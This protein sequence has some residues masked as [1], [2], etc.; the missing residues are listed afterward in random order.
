MKAESPVR[1]SPLDML[2]F[3]QCT[4][5]FAEDPERVAEHVQDCRWCAEY[6]RQ[7]AAILK[8]SVSTEGWWNGRSSM[9]A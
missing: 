8:A 1:V 3:E 7:Q 9:F 4:H 5:L 2:A 6:K